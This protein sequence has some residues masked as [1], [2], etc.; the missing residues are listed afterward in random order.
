MTRQ[1]LRARLGLLRAASRALAGTGLL[2]PSPWS[3]ALH[4]L[5]CA[6]R[7]GPSLYAVVAWNARRWPER[8]AVRGPGGASSFRALLTQADELAARLTGLLPAHTRTPPKVALLH[9]NHVMFVVLLLACSRLGLQCLLLNTTLSARELLDLCRAEGVTVLLGETVL[10][11]GDDLAAALEAGGLP[12]LS[13]CAL[14]ARPAAPLPFRARQRASFLLLTSGTTGV[15]RTVRQRPD[16]WRLLQTATALTERLQLRAGSRTL[17]TLPL[18]HGHGLATLH[19]SLTLA[20]PLYLCRGSDP[21][22]H[23]RALQ[24]EQIEVLVLVPTV[25]HRLLLSPARVP[26]PQLRQVVSGS[27]PLG[28]GLAAQARRQFGPVLF[29]LYGL[30]ETGLISLATPE[31]LHAAPGSVGLVLPGAEVQVQPLPGAPGGGVGLLAVR[32]AFTPGAAPALITGDLG[33]FGAGGRLYLTGRQGDLL[34]IGGENV[35]PE[36]VE[37]RIATLPYVRECAVSPLP[38]AEYGQRL[39]AHLVLRP[40]SAADVHSIGRDL[41]AL[42]PR[43]LRPAHISVV[44]ALPRNAAGKLTRSQLKPPSPGPYSSELH[45][46]GLHSPDQHSPGPP[47]DLAAEAGPER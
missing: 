4:L 14:S 20:S 32:G 30:S 11:C 29:N 23:W 10:L 24:D 44:A 27:A 21:A 3:S 28:G 12:V 15:P 41:H 26:L 5:W 35:A 46:S 47:H 1:G 37:G 34:L 31:D 19:L 45:R 9:R 6:A 16:L 22:E 17:L 13:V 33:R 2:G 7:H 43:R 8:T 42:L 40:G 18:F 39:H 25:L 38:C 36:T